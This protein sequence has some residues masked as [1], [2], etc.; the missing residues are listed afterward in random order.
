[1]TIIEKENKIKKMLKDYYKL[2]TGEVSYVLGFIAGA[3]A[4]KKRVIKEEVKSNG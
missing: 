1:M 4:N 2:E 3:N